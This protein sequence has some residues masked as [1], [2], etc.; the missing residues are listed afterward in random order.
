MECFLRNMR[1]ALSLH[2]SQIEL[3]LFFLCVSS[4]AHVH[5]TRHCRWVGG[6]V[7]HQSRLKLKGRCASGFFLL[8][9]MKF[10]LRKKYG[11]ILSKRFDLNNC[12]GTGQEINNF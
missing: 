10:I 6:G 4:P 5:L 7:Q 8:T 3:A 9:L 1:A 2:H 11:W 12:S